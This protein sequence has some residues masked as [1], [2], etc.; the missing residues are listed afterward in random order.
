MG[1]TS[2]LILSVTKKHFSGILNEVHLEESILTHLT[3]SVLKCFTASS[4]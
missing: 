2:S 3:S 4:L 1:G